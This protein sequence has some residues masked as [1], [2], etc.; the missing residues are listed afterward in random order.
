MSECEVTTRQYCAPG[1]ERDAGRLYESDYKVKTRY[2]FDFN[3]P[4]P[5]CSQQRKAARDCKTPMKS[6]I[7]SIGSFV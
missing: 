3:F 2:L 5:K 1:C 4:L 7:V 6:N